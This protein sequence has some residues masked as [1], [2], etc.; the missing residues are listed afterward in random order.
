GTYLDVFSLGAIAYH[1]FTGQPPAQ[2]VAELGEKLRA[3]HGLQLSAVIDGVGVA[4]N[5]LVAMAT[6]PDVSVRLATMDDFLAALELAE[7][8][9]T[10]P[11]DAG[12]A[13]PTEARAGDLLAGGYKVKKRIGQGSVS[14][15]YLVD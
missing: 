4:L 8:E 13:N 7:D 1:V 2:S 12:P 14:I 5:D 11:D 15:V 3:A 10:R 9:L 6:H